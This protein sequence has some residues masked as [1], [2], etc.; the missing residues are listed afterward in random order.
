MAF[1]GILKAS[2]RGVQLLLGG[3]VRKAAT[4]PFGLFGGGGFTQFVR[5]I[6]ENIIALK[7][8]GAGGAGKQNAA[9]AAAST[10]F[11]NTKK[12]K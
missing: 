9:K 1:G 12:G 6:V 10:F 7:F 5:S 2:L 11:N 8:L 3:L 4:I